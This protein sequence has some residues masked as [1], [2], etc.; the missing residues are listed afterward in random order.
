[1]DNYTLP[2]LDYLFNP[3]LLEWKQNPDFIKGEAKLPPPKN[4]S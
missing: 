4:H 2:D 3:I 1:M